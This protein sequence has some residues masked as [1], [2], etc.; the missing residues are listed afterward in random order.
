M[1]VDNKHHRNVDSSGAVDYDDVTDAFNGDA[2]SLVVVWGSAIEVRRVLVPFALQSRIE[3]KRAPRGVVVSRPRYPDL[4]QQ[5]VAC[6]PFP[7]HPFNRKRNYVAVEWWEEHTSSSL[8]V[9]E[10]TWHG[11]LSCCWCSGSP[12]HKTY[13]SKVPKNKGRW[14][15]SLF[16]YILLLAQKFSQGIQS[17][18]E[19]LQSLIG[20]VYSSAW[21]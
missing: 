8:V 16:I 18:R 15:T 20:Y 21:G 17:R 7:K 5:F 6:L 2:L 9:G 1:G 4:H 14:R 12:P 10:S 11:I 3:W 13:R 19:M